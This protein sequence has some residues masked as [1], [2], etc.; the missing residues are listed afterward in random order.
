MFSWFQAQGLEEAFVTMFA[1]N[2]IM[3]FTV[4]T[5]VYLIFNKSIRNALKQLFHIQ[6]V[7]HQGTVAGNA[8]KSQRRAGQVRVGHR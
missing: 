2:N 6:N 7:I 5:Y 3:F 4:N 8:N 1:F